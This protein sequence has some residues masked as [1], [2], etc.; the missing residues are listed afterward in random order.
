MQLVSLCVFAHSSL[1]SLLVCIVMGIYEK[2]VI[3]VCFYGICVQSLSWCV[4]KGVSMQHVRLCVL[5]DE[6]AGS[7]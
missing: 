4:Y 6:S 7:L 3:C 2:S 5:V 1:Y